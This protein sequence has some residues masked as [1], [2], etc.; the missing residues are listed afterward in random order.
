MQTK[1]TFDNQV[2]VNG[3]HPNWD[4]C[5]CILSLNFQVILSTLQFYPCN[6]SLRFDDIC[7]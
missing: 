5:Y 2:S 1:F 7:E 3:M 6:V 4:V